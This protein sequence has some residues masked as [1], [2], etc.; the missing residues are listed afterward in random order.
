MLNKSYLLVVVENFAAYANYDLH[1]TMQRGAVVWSVV[2]T[3]TMIAKLM[4]HSQPSLVVAS[5]DKMLHVDYLCLV[6]SGKRQIK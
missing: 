3:T 1:A 6:K 4:V 5:L 2:F